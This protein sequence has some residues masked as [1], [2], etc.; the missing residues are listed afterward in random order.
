MS[1]APK[2]MNT[3]LVKKEITWW[4]SAFLERAAN[5]GP[6]MVVA[7]VS[8]PAEGGSD[9]IKSICHPR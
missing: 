6:V 5:R 4:E 2:G 1:G 8:A 7:Y 9:Q 3:Y